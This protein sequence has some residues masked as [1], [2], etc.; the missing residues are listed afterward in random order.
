QLF[1]ERAFWLFSTGHRLGDLRRLV[2]Q[3]DRAPDTVFP[4]GA[5]LEGGSYGSDMNFPVPESEKNNPNDTAGACIDRN[6]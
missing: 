6:A 4:N 2:R 3:Y 1:H 5:F